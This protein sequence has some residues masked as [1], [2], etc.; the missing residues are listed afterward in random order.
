MCP[1]DSYT[2]VEHVIGVT[3]AWRHMS[4]T[5]R[6]RC[7][8]SPRPATT[9]SAP[10]TVS[11]WDDVCSTTASSCSVRRFASPWS[12]S[13]CSWRPRSLLSSCPPPWQSSSWAAC[14]CSSSAPWLRL[15]RSPSSVSKRHQGK[16]MVD[17]R[18]HLVAVNLCLQQWKN[19]LPNAQI[20]KG[21]VFFW[22]T[23]YKFPSSW[24]W[25]CVHVQRYCSR[26]AWLSIFE[27][28]IVFSVC[29]LPSR[30]YLSVSTSWSNER[31]VW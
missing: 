22:L 29:L 24:V 13:R 2:D 17:F 6:H 25:P 20:K 11:A 16:D 30:V 15:P 1:T 3:T 12:F 8:L 18:I 14:F 31:K 19:C 5:W 27:Y 28:S 9:T 21:P 26:C 23:V 7:L 10:A 4:T